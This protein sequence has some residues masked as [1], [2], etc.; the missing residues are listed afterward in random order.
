MR[1]LRWYKPGKFRHIWIDA[2]CINQQDNDE[3]STQVQMMLEIYARAKRVNIWLGEA[4]ESTAL[5]FRWLRWTGTP[6]MPFF[7]VRQH[8]E[9]AA[10][11]STTQRKRSFFYFLL[12]SCDVSALWVVI[13]ITFVLMFPVRVLP[14]FKG[15]KRKIQ[16]GVE[17]LAAREYW[18]RSWTVQ[19]ASVNFNAY[20]L[21]GS[22][23]PLPIISF[24][25][26]H[27]VVGAFYVFFGL[28]RI[29]LRYRLYMPTYNFFTG[30]EVLIH[31]ALNSLCKTK[32]TLP[33]DKIFAIRAMYPGSLGTM[34]VDYSRPAKDV[35]TD[36]ARLILKSNKNVEFFRYACTGNRTDGFP[37]WVPA[38]D[39]L[40][41]VPELYSKFKPAAVSPQP[42]VDQE[43]EKDVLKLKALRVDAVTANVSG[44]FPARPPLKRPWAPSRS[45][46]EDP[47]EAFEVFKAWAVAPAD[48]NDVT[49]D[50][51]PKLIQFASLLAD[52][53][54]LKADQ[55]CEWF[56]RVWEYSDYGLGQQF[57]YVIAPREVHDARK[58]ATNLLQLTSNRALFTTKSG[59][60]GIST[61]VVCEGDEIVLF[62]GEQMP[63]LIR[64]CPNR[65]GKYILVC[66]CWISGAVKGEVWPSRSGDGVEEDLEYIE[67]V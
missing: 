35:F 44:L 36:A 27:F 13:Y 9:I 42:I 41:V 23:A 31:S 21:C 14:I 60:V 4:D 50:I 58:F 64:K 57:G 49:N 65:P 3:K 20:I 25:M 17:N 55:I 51:R 11:T 6:F 12:R 1:R 15:F 67:L 28:E 7:F 56:P 30:A 18:E 38:W 47:D 10:L 61:L 62:S 39:T 59:R 66:P 53:C 29:P 5:I 45:D 26:G 46:F 63:Y 22:S 33:V 32:A 43:N 48:P 2:I 40:N 54:N 19:E 37:T 8:I 34:T 16:A 24:L 52:M